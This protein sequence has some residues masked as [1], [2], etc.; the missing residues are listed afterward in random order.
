MGF[1]ICQKYL[2]PGLEPKI[3]NSFGWASGYWVS[4]QVS[5]HKYHKK[6]SLWPQPYSHQAPKSKVPIGTIQ[7][8]CLPKWAS[9]LILSMPP[10]LDFMTWQVSCGKTHSKNGSICAPEKRP[11]TSFSNRVL[12]GAAWIKKVLQMTRQP[13]ESSNSCKLCHQTFASKASPTQ[14][15]PAQNP[16]SAPAHAATCFRA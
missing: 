15:K 3:P 2:E 4:Y 1:E 8:P 5:A 13:D 14:W 10:F 7:I 16:T 12:P 11:R 9:S 6:H